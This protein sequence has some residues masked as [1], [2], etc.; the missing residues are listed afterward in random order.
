M[1][2]SLVTKAL[3]SLETPFP[4]TTSD[5]YTSKLDQ[6]VARRNGEEEP[7][8]QAKPAEQSVQQTA[9]AEID[10]KLKTMSQD[11]M[12]LNGS[13][14]VLL[15]RALNIAYAKKDPA[16]Q[17]F[18]GVEPSTL[19][20][21]QESQTQDAYITAARANIV[22]AA[23]GRRPDQ[24]R[25]AYEEGPNHA[26][27]TIANGGTGTKLVTV[28]TQEETVRFFNSDDVSDQD[29][30]FVFYNKFPVKTDGS[31]PRYDEKS[32]MIILNEKTGEGLVV[33]SIQI[34]V[35]TRPQEEKSE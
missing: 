22:S 32:G 34:V 3:E 7:P 15:S 1:K 8:L 10:E 2:T 31:K 5:I 11:K 23:L 20:V 30:E 6:L 4:T 33:E 35:T 25:E 13:L 19:A 24:L 21:G 14:S 29:L 12:V 26:D 9:D 28:A 16:T 27:E 17:R 18:E